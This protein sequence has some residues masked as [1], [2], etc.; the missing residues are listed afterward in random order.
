MPDRAIIGYCFGIGVFFVITTIFFI[1]I[2][3]A[4]EKII[5]KKKMI[6]SIYKYE[7]T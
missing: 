5:C 7:I 3:D 1:N 4:Y 2:M 6:L